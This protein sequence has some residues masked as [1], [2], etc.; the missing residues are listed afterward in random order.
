MCLFP[1]E[2]PTADSPGLWAQLHSTNL[3]SSVTVASQLIFL[4]C[5]SPHLEDGNN[6]NN[7]PQR[8]KEMCSWST[9]RRGRGR[10][11]V[12]ICLGDVCVSFKT[13]LQH[14]LPEDFLDTVRLLG[15]HL[16]C[17]SCAIT[18]L[19]VPM[20]T[21]PPRL[22]ILRGGGLTLWFWSS[23]HFLIHRT[24]CLTSQWMGDIKFHLSHD[25]EGIDL[26]AVRVIKLGWFVSLCPGTQRREELQRNKTI[27]FTEPK[28]CFLRG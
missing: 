9:H 8:R 15:T 12:F 22:P 26:W 4:M 2:M 14:C 17:D 28:I 18:Y 23:C 13:Q 24:R 27:G 10:D 19:F 20:P 6:S 16:C 5:Q 1:F 21:T 3:L 7:F 25:A 11:G